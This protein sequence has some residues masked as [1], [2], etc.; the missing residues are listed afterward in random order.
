VTGKIVSLAAKRAEV[1]HA[2]KALIEAEPAPRVHSSTYHTARRALDAIA[3]FLR[4]YGAP[5]GVAGTDPHLHLFSGHRLAL[6]EMSDTAD[7]LAFILERE[8]A[9]AS[10]FRWSAAQRERSAELVGMIEVALVAIADYRRE[11]ES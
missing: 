3:V 6:G 2:S 11:V 4:E 5:T 7:D 1:A 9:D 8:V 10:T